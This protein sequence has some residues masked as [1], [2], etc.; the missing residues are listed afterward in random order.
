M[1]STD[2]HRKEDWINNG[3]KM[4]EFEKGLQDLGIRFN[5]K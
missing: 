5:V 3:F 4:Q 2:N 1:R